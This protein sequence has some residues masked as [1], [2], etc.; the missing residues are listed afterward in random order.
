MIIEAT[1]LEA[2]SDIRERIINIKHGIVINLEKYC[3]VIID[4]KIYRPHGNVSRYSN[5][6]DKQ[7]TLTSLSDN[8]MN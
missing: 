8:I 6:N 2:I 5:I 1:Q 7:W 4:K 3:W